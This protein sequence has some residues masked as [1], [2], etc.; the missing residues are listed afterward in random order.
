MRNYAQKTD[1][2]RAVL[3]LRL[4]VE[5]VHHLRDARLLEPTDWRL[6]EDQA[7]AVDAIWQTCLETGIDPDQ[8]CSSRYCDCHVIIAERKPPTLF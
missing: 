8:L 7:D 4:L 6:Y 3:T 2:S 1:R 5:Q